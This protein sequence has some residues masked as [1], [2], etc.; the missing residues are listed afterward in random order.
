MEIVHF[1]NHMS[2]KIRWDVI[3]D[4]EAGMEDLEV[5]LLKIWRMRHKG[6]HL[7]K[8]SF[9]SDVMARYEEKHKDPK[10]R[11]MLTPKQLLWVV[12]LARSYYEDHQSL[13]KA[14]VD[15]PD[16]DLKP[17][18]ATLICA[19]GLTKKQRE[20]LREIRLQNEVM[21]TVNTTEC[22]LDPL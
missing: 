2:D 13:C 5:E 15:F 4:E 16:I 8:N 14:T 19:G 6:V 3:N 22:K 10:Q 1:T 12:R 21:N 7:G 18:R 20:E 17:Y 9:F 11:A